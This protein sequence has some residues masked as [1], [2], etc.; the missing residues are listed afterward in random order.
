MEFINSLLAINPNYILIG[1][2][3][4]FYSLEQLLGN[5][6]KFD[7]RPQHLFQN[8]LFY[9][10]FFLVGILWSFVSVFSIEWLNNHQI[11][12]FYLVQLP[13]WLKLLVG[14]ALFD[15]VSYW[16]HRL[17]HVVPFLWRF[18]RVH[19]SDTT[20][21]ASTNF[22]GH[23]LESFLWFGSSNILAAAVFGLDLLTLG[24]Y[25]FITMIFFVLQHSNLRFPK[26]LDKSLGLVITTP[27]IHKVHHEQDQSYTDSNFS[28]I[29]IL[30]D[31]LFG[32]YKSKP[33]EQ[34]KLGLKEF[35]E[36]KKQTFW[37][38]MK[39]PFLEIKR[40]E[41]EELNKNTNAITQLN[42]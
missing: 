16:F 24:L 35:D 6:F 12:L 9:V 2:M 5:Q 40:V 18:H 37:Y 31:R 22:R 32:T 7:K 15:L 42:K 38:L 20:M 25:L 28:D 33:V 1:L 11:G 29:F 39:S 36:E 21:D 3:V 30:W 13:L 19:H 14:V 17:S 4:L 41:S 34:I 10:V 8:S 27:N 26:W 23:P